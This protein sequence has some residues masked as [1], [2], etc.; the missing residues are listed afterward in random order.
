MTKRKHLYVIGILCLFLIGLGVHGFF[1]LETGRSLVSWRHSLLPWQHWQYS[2]LL[3]TSAAFYSSGLIGL[4]ALLAESLTGGGRLKHESAEHENQRDNAVVS[5]KCLCLAGFLCLLLCGLGFLGFVALAHSTLPVYQQLPFLLASVTFYCPGLIGFIAVF[6]ISLTDSKWFK[7]RYGGSDSPRENAA[8]KQKRLSPILIAIGALSPLL[9]FLSVKIMFSGFRSVAW[10]GK[11]VFALA[12][13]LF[14]AAGPVGCAAVL[15]L[16]ILNRK[17]F[18]DRTARLEIGLW[19]LLLALLFA[20]I[21]T[22][23]PFAFH[24]AEVVRGDFHAFHVFR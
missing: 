3:V 15:T 5:R 14:Y 16:F 13:S 24:S 10:A 20:N 21:L 1:V 2:L 7:A 23:P 11:P 4:I 17:W 22:T 8:A 6:I 19:L 18:G 12:A 9:W